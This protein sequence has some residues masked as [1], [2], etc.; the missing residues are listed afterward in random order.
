MFAVSIGGKEVVWPEDLIQS[1][2]ESGHSIHAKV[3]LAITNFGNG[4]CVKEDDGTWTNIP[5]ALL[6]RSGHE[7]S[8]GRP[9]HCVLNHGGFHL[10]VDGPLLKCECGHHIAID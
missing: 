10:V 3:L 8:Q 1:L 2:M 7:D 4:L 5:W 9:T 6:L